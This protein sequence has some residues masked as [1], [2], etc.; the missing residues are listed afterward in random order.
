VEALDD[1]GEDV[2][3]GQHLGRTIANE[4][5]DLCVRGGRAHYHQTLS[6]K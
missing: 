2:A 4:R 5:L 1:L 6:V 3:S